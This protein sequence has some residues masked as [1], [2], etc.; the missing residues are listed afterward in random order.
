MSRSASGWVGRVQ[1]RNVWN[2]EN[3]AAE[4]LLRTLRIKS[5]KYHL[6]G[7]EGRCRYYALQY[8]LKFEDHSIIIYIV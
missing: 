2:D 8:F 1:V 6:C 7:L 4:R 5:F 3:T